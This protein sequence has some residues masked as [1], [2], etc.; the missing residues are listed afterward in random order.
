MKKISEL[1][2]A[3]TANDGD[4]LVIVQG[5]TTKRVPRSAVN[6]GADE[7]RS[8]AAAAGRVLTANGTG[9]ASYIIPMSGPR[10]VA[11]DTFDRPDSTSL[12]VANSGQTWQRSGSADLSI[13]S[14]MM[15]YAT[16]IEGTAHAVGLDA[17]V[18]DVRV[19]GWL[20]RTIDGWQGLGA[21]MDNPSGGASLDGVYC[22]IARVGLTQEVQVNGFA[23]AGFTVWGA[24]NF[25]AA[26]AAVDQWMHA[27]LIVVGDYCRVAFNGVP[28]LTVTLPAGPAGL[29]GTFAGHRWRGGSGGAGQR[30][31]LDNFRVEALR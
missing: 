18:K 25:P 26:L 29:T 17:G 4:H 28:V 24:A 11:W 13:T 31:E 3:S 10:V 30:I 27:E 16:A 12:G 20:R 7:L 19:S 8:G 15:R 14:G 2:L 9:G 21:R 1:P 23:G 22:R 6:P 5:G